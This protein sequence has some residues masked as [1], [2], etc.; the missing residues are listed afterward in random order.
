LPDQASEEA[1]RESAPARRGVSS[2]KREAAELLAGVGEELG[3]SVLLWRGA[4][5]GGS[6]VDLVT[7]GR[8]EFALARRLSVAGLKPRP[9][10]PQHVT[11]SRDDRSSLPIDVIHSSAW[12]PYYPS[13]AGVLS[14]AEMTRWGIPVASPAD[15]ALIVA[16]EAI[17]GRPLDKVVRRLRELTSAPEEQ[18][19]I[20]EVGRSEGLD[21]LAAVAADPDGL[22]ARSRRG[23]LPY[24]RA[25]PVAIASRAARA[26]LTARFRARVRHLTRFPPR[27]RA[28]DGGVA[29][30]PFLITIS[31]MDGSGKSTAAEVI[32]GELE[33]R[34]VPAEI[35]WARLG[36][37]GALPDRLAETVRTLLRRR[38]SIAD[39]VASGGPGVREVRDPREAAGRRR[40]VSWA[41]ILIVALVSVRSE[42]RAAALRRQGRT[43][44]CDRWT[45]D[46]MVDLE[47]RYGRHRAAERTLS[48]LTPRPDLELLIQID[49]LTAARRKPGDQA[50]RVLRAMEAG[51]KR[52]VSRP[53][54]TAVDGTLPRAEVDAALVEQLE[55]LLDRGRRSSSRRSRS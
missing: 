12:P 33:A 9:G 23:R 8:A 15:R 38:G 22:A 5:L 10:D 27:H 31:G 13:L 46:A 2:R 34:G 30:A 35:A 26:A 48:A 45:T 55:P 28:G 51:Y 39:P 4:D 37:K 24:V 6:D 49:S 43:V 36:M 19:R 52:L 18:A 17:A 42:W 29:D 40:F 1:V 25:I 7:I 20:A 3:D 32:R 11:W 53:G 54:L 50:E 44:I 41:W 21:E 47:V 14:R 16:A